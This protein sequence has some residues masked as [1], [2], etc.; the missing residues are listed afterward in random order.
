MAT[1]RRMAPDRRGL[2]A[3]TVIALGAALGSERR[4]RSDRR[5]RP[6]RRADVRTIADFAHGINAGETRLEVIVDGTEGLRLVGMFECGCIAV[7]P[8]GNGA[9]HVKLETCAA[10]R[11]PAVDIERRRGSRSVS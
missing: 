8:V 10:H 9:A 7:E 1:E 3:A 5:Q 11:E 6:R 4:D 2:A